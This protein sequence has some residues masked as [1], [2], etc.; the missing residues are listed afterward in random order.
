MWRQLGVRL[1]LVCLALLHGLTRFSVRDRHHSQRALRSGEPVLYA[2]RGAQSWLLLMGYPPPAPLATLVAPGASYDAVAELLRLKGFGVIRGATGANGRAALYELTELVLDGGLAAV[3]VDEPR[4]TV[5]S[6][7]VELARD[8]QAPIVPLAAA[9]AKPW[10]LALAGGA[11]EL[12]KPFS[13]CVILE[14]E[15][16]RIAPE[17]D[18]RELRAAAKKLEAQLERLCREALCL[19][20]TNESPN[21][22]GSER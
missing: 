15:P 5:Q 6:G 1:A 14:G 10:S 18:D 17:S 21:A 2:L 9:C 11:C 13:R 4:G 20:T 3:V 22:P 8:T 12:P 16:L 7:I 19:A